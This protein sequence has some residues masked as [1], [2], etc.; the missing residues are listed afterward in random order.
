MGGAPDLK[1]PYCA[2][3][4]LEDARFCALCLNPM[5]SGGRGLS[6]SSLG[7]IPGD[8]GGYVSPGE[9]RGELADRMPLLREDVAEKVSRFR[10][11]HIVF[12]VIVLLIIV[13]TALM[14]TVWGAKT[15][16]QVTSQFMEAAAAGDTEL[17]LAFV[18]PGKTAENEEFVST[19]SLELRGATF[20]DLRIEID[21]TDQ[22]I[23]IARIMGGT[24]TSA[25]SNI[26]TVTAGDDLFAELRM[27]GGKWY[28]YPGEARLAPSDL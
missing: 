12:S 7:K 16:A 9:W 8:P 26:H 24:I 28:L 17:A 15:P 20:K 2:E 27:Q 19:W 11:R 3:E 6:T 21:R 25:G 5:K 18:L 14:V 1:C 10:I 22:D 13:F 4:N 23:A